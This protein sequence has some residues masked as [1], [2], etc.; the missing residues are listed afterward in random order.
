[1]GHA[2]QAAASPAH[3]PRH[4]AGCVHAHLAVPLAEP[5]AGLRA[6]C[7]PPFC[8]GVISPLAG[9]GIQGPRLLGCWRGQLGSPP[10]SRFQV[11]AGATGPAQ[12]G[13]VHT[14]VAGVW[15]STRGN[16]WPCLSWEQV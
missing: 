9:V 5:W 15:P 14:P 13:P 1:M 6:L 2:S 11:P 8:L 3:P 7:L 12:E 10:E 16:S 4:L